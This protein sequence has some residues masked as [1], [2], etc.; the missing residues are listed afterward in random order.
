MSL[1]LLLAVTLIAQASCHMS[2]QDPPARNVMW[3]MGFSALPEHRDDDY[4]ICNEN[5]GRKC[6][7]C[8]DS[9]DSPPPHPHEAGGV[10]ATGIITRTYSEGETIEVHVNVTRSHGGYV[11]LKLCPNNDVN[12]PVTQSCLDQYPLQIAGQSSTKFK[13]S[14]PYDSPEQ[15]RFKAVLPAG[16]TCDQ[17]VIQMTNNAAQFK[18]QTVMFRNCADI[19]IV[20]GGGSRGA[21]VG[22]PVSFNSPSARQGGSFGRQPFSNHRHFG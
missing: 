15:L 5:G 17:C 10:W 3:R 16:V 6:P 19:A 18:P 1:A 9:I 22:K 4:L 7:P 12:A 2:L 8:G 13:I 11:Q 14:A 20:P 21:P